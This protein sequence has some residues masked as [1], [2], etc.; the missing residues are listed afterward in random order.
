MARLLHL[1][2]ASGILLCVL[3]GGLCVV[4]VLVGWRVVW[5][6]MEYSFPCTSGAETDIAYERRSAKAPKISSTIN[7]L[8][9]MIK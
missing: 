6:N 3:V 9:V 4:C 2:F 8:Y 5:G 1:S 7:E